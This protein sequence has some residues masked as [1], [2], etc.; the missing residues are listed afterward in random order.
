MAPIYQKTVRKQYGGYDF[1]SAK[2][3]K[4][5]Q[6]K[7]ILALKEMQETVI[8]ETAEAVN[9]NEDMFE[10]EQQ[11]IEV[12]F[13]F[14]N[15]NNID[16]RLDTSTRNLSLSESDNV[17]G[18][19][20]N[21]FYVSDSLEDEEPEDEMTD[22]E[23]TN[24]ENNSLKSIS[25]LNLIYQFIIISVAFFVTLYVVDEEA[26]I[27]IAIVNKILQ[28]LFDLFCLPVNIPG[29][30]RLAGFNVLTNGIKKYI[31]YSKCHTI[32]ENN[33]TSPICCTLPMF[34]KCSLCNNSLFKTGSGSRVPKKTFVFHLVKKALKTFFQ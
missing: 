15:L 24:D 12:Y 29:L 31:A 32:Y 3:F 9:Y 13:V 20:V 11:D 16:C 28:F 8:W 19:E 1:V 5:Y 25:E 34:G 2:T 21:T 26:V 23:M 33:N 17:F 22:N 4:H 30:K 7:D 27:L 6:E 14:K 18:D 10:I